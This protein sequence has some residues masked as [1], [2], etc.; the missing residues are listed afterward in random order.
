MKQEL[1]YRDIEKLMVYDQTSLASDLGCE[2]YELVNVVTI[3]NLLEVIRKYHQIDVYTVDSNWCIQ[4]FD[5]DVAANDQ[6]DCIYENHHEELINVLY[7]S[8]EWIYD[9]ERNRHT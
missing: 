6:V 1:D 4:L 2:L 9:H 8:L 7:G 3:G 5:F